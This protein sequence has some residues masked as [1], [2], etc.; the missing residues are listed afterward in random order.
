MNLDEI[1]DRISN[2]R[3]LEELERKPVLP[4]DPSDS[5]E[6]L[7]EAKS[8]IRFLYAQ[9]QEMKSERT[10]L[11]TLLEEMRLDLKESRKQIEKK[12]ESESRLLSNIERLMHELSDARAEISHLV[13]VNSS[14]VEQISVLKKHRYGSPSQR[15]QRRKDAENKD[16]SENPSQDRN[17]EKDGFDGTSARRP[18]E[19]GMASVQSKEKHNSGTDQTRKGCKYSKM[20]ADEKI[21]HKSDVTLLPQG[22]TYLWTEIRKAFEQITKVVEHDYEVFYYLDEQGKPQCGYFADRN[23]PNYASYIDR[24]PGTHASAGFLANL[25]YDKYVMST[26]YHREMEKVA[27]Q[28]MSTCRQTLMNWVR[29]P[30]SYLLKVVE[31]FKVAALK[32][33]TV[34]N[35]DETWHKLV[36]K[37]SKKVYIWCLVNE[38]EKIVL[39]FYD[40]GSRSRASLKEFLG[41]AKLDALQSDGYNVYMYL[42]DLMIDADH[43]C[44]MAHARAKFM[45][46]LQQ[47][48]YKQVEKILGLIEKLYDIERWIKGKPCERVL[49]VRREKSES[50]KKMIRKELDNLKSQLKLPSDDL[51]TKAVN[52]METFWKQLFLYLKDGRYTIDNLAAERAIRPLAVERNNSMFFCSHKGAETSVLYHT[53]IATCKKQGYKVLDYLK[54]FFKQIILGR[55]DYE[56]LM[57]ATIGIR[58]INKS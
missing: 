54:E 50:I 38:A 52:Y 28:D 10:D 42:D 8:Y 45:Y 40:K 57:P 35:V 18:V 33:G 9:V 20:E 47:G 24:F 2:I 44:C 30:Y 36:L 31:Q 21:L 1:A 37:K 49:A 41:D 34:V 27:A 56:N 5:M 51:L 16:E 58:S 14:L 22:A 7:E 19:T 6:T 4:Y 55:C 43:L 3:T 23:D 46:A 15:N 32:D 12:N 53:I 13:S 39:F 48:H 29:K 17:E 25:V 11:K 26:P